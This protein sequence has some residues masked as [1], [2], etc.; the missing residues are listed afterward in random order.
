MAQHDEQVTRGH[1]IVADGCAGAANPHPHPI[2][3]LKKHLKCSFS[4]FSTRVHGPMQ[5]P[6]RRADGRTD[7][8]TKPF[9]EL[10]VR[11]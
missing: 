11:N 5:R 1:N 6:D 7:G 2:P 10:R 8:R 9:I 3:K 4:H